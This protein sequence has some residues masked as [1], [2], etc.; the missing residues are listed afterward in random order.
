MNDEVRTVGISSDGQIS[1]R[2]QQLPAGGEAV[3]V[4]S[5][6]TVVVPVIGGTMRQFLDTG[7]EPAWSRDGTRLAYHA[8]VRGDPIFVADRNGRDA[9]QIFTAPS[10]SIHC[11]YLA[12]SPDGR[13]IYFVGGIPPNEMDIWRV[14]SDGGAAERITNRPTN[15]AYLTPIDDRTL[16]Y[17]GLDD[18]GSGPWLYGM[19]VVRRTTHRVSLG[20]EHYLSIAAT[21]DGR[22]L[23]A[24]VSNPSGG[25]WTIPVTTGV[26]SEQAAERVS[27]PSV[28]ALSPRYGPDYLLYLSSQGGPNGLWRFKDGAA[29]ELW[30]AAEGGITTPPAVSPD[31]RQVAFSARRGGRSR[32]FVMDHDGGNLRPLIGDVEVRDAVSWSPDGTSI[33]AAAGDGLIK[34][35]VDTG[36]P[37]ILVRTPC[38]LPIWSSDGR[39]ILYSE[40]RGGPGFT[41]KAITPDRKP[42]P[43]PTLWVRRGLDR[44]RVLPDGRQILFLSGEYGNQNF[45]LLDIVGGTRRQITQLKPGF[46]IRGFDLSP[47]G[48]RIVF[49][50]VRENSDVVLIDLPG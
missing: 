24:T 46:S 45:W 28:T 21:A 18:D 50:R 16:L 20:V 27:L 7:I 9:K 47:D 44:Y 3:M 2:T 22:R 42:F 39:Y 4:G 40:P 1:I 36:T 43:I 38:R 48:T 49:D 31:G 15:I 32:L 19:D 12:W 5:T 11:H 13:F 6:R 10:E 37:E 30:K 23:V 29:T 26:A 17:R 33:V 35:A 14:S 8:A 34:V 25:L 41:V